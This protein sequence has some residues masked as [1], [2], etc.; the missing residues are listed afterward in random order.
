MQNPSAGK[1]RSLVERLSQ[2]SQHFTNTNTFLYMCAA[3][4]PLLSTNILC[5]AQGSLYFTE[6]IRTDK[7]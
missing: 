6:Q 1:T 2:F 3:I 4:K 7:P 5:Q